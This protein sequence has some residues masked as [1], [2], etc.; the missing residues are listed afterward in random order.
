MPQTSPE[1]GDF[2]KATYS[3]LRVSLIAEYRAHI[4]SSDLNPFLLR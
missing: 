1:A 2:V 4:Y 3:L